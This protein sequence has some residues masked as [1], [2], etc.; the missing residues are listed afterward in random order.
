MLISSHTND[1]PTSEH[2]Q[3][4]DAPLPPP[5]KP[6]PFRTSGLQQSYAPSRRDIPTEDMA[7]PSIESSMDLTNDSPRRVNYYGPPRHPQVMYQDVEPERRYLP[8]QPNTTYVSNWENNQ[9]KRRRLMLADD[10]GNVPVS[11]STVDGHIRLVPISR[12][13]QS[14]IATPSLTRVVEVRDTSERHNEPI[15]I[16]QR[17][18]YPRYIQRVTDSR[19]HDEFSSMTEMRE[20]TGIDRERRIITEDDSSPHV[21]IVSRP[22]GP[23]QSH[24]GPQYTLGPQTIESQRIRDRHYFETSRPKK[25]IQDSFDERKRRAEDRTQ[26]TQQVIYTRAPPHYHREEEQSSSSSLS[27]FP[28]YPHSNEVNSGLVSYP[29]ISRPDNEYASRFPSPRDEPIP[30]SARISHQFL[31]NSFTAD[32]FERHRLVDSITLEV[33]R[34]IY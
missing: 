22:L 7:L 4:Y 18:E 32:N 30:V 2:R 24:N 17:H 13:E 16:D 6:L 14:A 34:I 25:L 23:N 3:G 8:V 29:T 12:S 27:T 31:Q 21:W 5:S 33:D 9:P 20:P 11:S 1:A 28:K 19:G 26:T 15:I 10:R